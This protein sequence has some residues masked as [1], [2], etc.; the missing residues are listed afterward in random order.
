MAGRKPVS[1]HEIGLFND[2]LER[3][4]A[5]RDFLDLFYEAFVA[6]S[7]EAAEKFRNTN[8]NTQKKVLK[9][10]LYMM[11]LAAMGKSEAEA[12]LERIAELHNRRHHD[13]SPEL[14]SLWLDCLVQTVKKVD[15]FCDANTER[16]WRI[17]MEPGIAFM[18]SRY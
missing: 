6:S 2:S 9:A 17:M 18:Q 7:A 1:D 16:A 5:R 4:T 13:V 10:S 8:F 15:P 12:H 11:M 14:Y 3:C